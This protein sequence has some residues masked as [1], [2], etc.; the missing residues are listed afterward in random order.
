MSTD[1]WLS[2]TLH[3]AYIKVT[4]KRAYIQHSCITCNILIINV[5][6]TLDWPVYILSI[7]FIHISNSKRDKNYEVKGGGSNVKSRTTS[8][9]GDPMW[10]FWLDIYIKDYLAFDIK[11]FILP[12]V[13]VIPQ[14]D[15]HATPK[16]HYKL[17]FH[18]LRSRVYLSSSSS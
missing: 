5:L 2:I 18:L 15:Y 4:S 8:S 16:N 7:S 11:H 3:K 14:H 6:M 17:P 10:S 9:Q 13:I 1:H 12:F